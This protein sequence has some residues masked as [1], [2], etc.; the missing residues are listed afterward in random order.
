VTSGDQSKEHV[1]K[2]IVIGTGTVGQAVSHTLTS[3]G[4]LVVTVGRKSG[5]RHAD[6]TDI[7]S[8]NS[9][10]ESVDGFGAVASAAG[11]VFPAPLEL[12]TDEQW[13]ASIAAK[14]R[15]QIDLVRAALPHIADNGSFTL[16]S[17]I[18]GEEITAA[19]TVGAT[20]NAMV[21]G[22]V[23]A[24]ATELPRGIRINC[25]SPTVLAESPQY[26]PYFP[27]YPPIPADAVANAYLRSISNPFTGRIL[28][29]H[30]T[31]R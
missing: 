25:V 1:M 29:L 14:G 4:H 26:Q 3:H 6:I 20:V 24:A 22:F 28:K 18:L 30:N 21:E 8:L 9:L 10:F 13:G 27:G 31:N 11:D 5:D 19:S 12:T 16:I 15:G 17:G 2:V 7:N 23:K